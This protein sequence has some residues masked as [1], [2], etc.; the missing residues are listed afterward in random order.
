M[1]MCK[2]EMSGYFQCILSIWDRVFRTYRERD[3]Y[4]AI[5]YGV[6][7]LT[8]ERFQTLS[9]LLATPFRKVG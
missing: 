2:S 5:R 1:K 8:G 9:G 7:G 4:R 3:D 6:A